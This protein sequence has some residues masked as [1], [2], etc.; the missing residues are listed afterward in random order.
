MAA[1]AEIVKA[2]P[3]NTGQNIPAIVK[4]GGKWRGVKIPGGRPPVNS[5]LRPRVGRPTCLSG[6]ESENRRVNRSSPPTQ[7]LG[8]WKFKPADAR[9]VVKLSLKLGYR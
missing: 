5:S 6:G 3:L 2:F 9:S 1:L 4:N 8:T 7:G